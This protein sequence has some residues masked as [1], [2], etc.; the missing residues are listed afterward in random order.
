MF[1]P[2][3]ESCATIQNK[4][5]KL[6][7]D[8]P[9]VADPNRYLLFVE[10]RV[11]LQYFPS[12]CNFFLWKCTSSYWW[13]SEHSH[14]A[15][16]ERHS[17]TGYRC[18]RC[19][20]LS[21]VVAISLKRFPIFVQCFAGVPSSLQFA[22]QLFLWTLVHGLKQ[23]SH[24]WM[25]TAVRVWKQILTL[26]EVAR[27]AAS[28]LPTFCYALSFL[29]VQRKRQKRIEAGS[30]APCPPPP[31]KNC[32]EGENTKRGSLFCSLSCSH[33]GNV[34]PTAESIGQEIRS[35]GFSVMLMPSLRACEDRIE[36]SHQWRCF[37]SHWLGPRDNLG[38]RP[39]WLRVNALE[40]LPVWLRENSP[41]GLHIGTDD[42]SVWHASL[43]GRNQGYKERLSSE[44]QVSRFML[45]L[46]LRW[47]R[48]LN[49]VWSLKV[50]FSFSQK[51]KETKQVPNFENTHIPVILFLSG[52]QMSSSNIF[53]GRTILIP[54]KWTLLC[55]LHNT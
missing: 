32:F 13:T 9:S 35:K 33:F 30:S 36:V 29:S 6:T 5:W 15:G 47:N 23:R 34:H 40:A 37:L 43:A 44:R 46:Q 11:W 3:V 20:K 21:H 54:R 38:P 19:Y 4:R 39:E 25:T 52:S 50:C 10:Q 17:D 16:V 8:R 55:H 26:I 49:W 24:D 14:E 27:S 1:V 41:V 28:C 22:W 48:Q 31:K 51:L 18:T 42:H 53:N 2:H 7:V 12:V 45:S